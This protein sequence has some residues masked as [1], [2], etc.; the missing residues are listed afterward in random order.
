M[1]EKS[2]RNSTDSIDPKR[3]VL[4][5]FIGYER[6]Q[7]HPASGMSGVLHLGIDRALDYVKGAAELGVREFLVFGPASTA[8]DNEASAATDLDSPVCTAI[9]KLSCSFPDCRFWGHVTLAHYTDHGGN[10]CL[11][12][13]GD[14]DWELTTDRFC[15]ICAALAASGAGIVLPFLLRPGAISSI[16]SHLQSNGLEDTAVFSYGAKFRSS[17]YGPFNRSTGITE[18]ASEDLQLE[19]WDREGAMEKISRDV[20]EGSEGI[21]IKPAL[22]YLDIILS[23]RS[24][25]KLPL[26]AY[27]VSGEYMMLRHAAAAGIAEGGASMREAHTSIF[28]A[29]ADL[30]IT[31]DALDLLKGIR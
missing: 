7:M 1:R 6:D 2:S 25:T 15:K 19:P 5:L 29:G 24:S 30:V 23:A 26:V 20:S 11:G 4:P 18:N 16:R 17:F 8:R 28:R 21:V 12:S 9:R 22:S 31:Y 14:I 3:L 13:N 27:M 10:Y